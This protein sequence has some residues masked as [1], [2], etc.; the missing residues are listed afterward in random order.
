MGIGQQLFP[1]SK[2]DSK[3]EEN[4]DKTNSIFTIFTRKHIKISNTCKSSTESLTRM[5]LNSYWSLW[6][7]TV[8]CIEY[9]W[10]TTDLITTITFVMVMSS[11]MRIQLLIFTLLSFLNYWSAVRNVDQEYI[12]LGASMK[13]MSIRPASF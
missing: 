6:R 7:R 13:I 2:I 9:Y 8:Q 4:F 1:D 10:I 3:N 11:N 12:F 5:L